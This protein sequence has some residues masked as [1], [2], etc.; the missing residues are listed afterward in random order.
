MTGETGKPR[1]SLIDFLHTF[2]PAY[3]TELT[4]E[5]MA[6]M[7]TVAGQASRIDELE[8]HM[9]NLQDEVD[10]LRDELGEKEEQ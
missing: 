3:A 2:A 1:G 9:G 4:K 10:Y 5:R 6:W 7:R 8:S